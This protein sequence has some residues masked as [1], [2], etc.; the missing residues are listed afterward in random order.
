MNISNML[1]GERWYR[2]YS[3]NKDVFIDPK[4]V[5]S[6]KIFALNDVFLKDFELFLTINNYANFLFY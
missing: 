3:V 5:K 1:L 6:A 4:Y 2:E